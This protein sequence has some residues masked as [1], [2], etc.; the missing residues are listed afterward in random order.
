[1]VVIDTCALTTDIAI[2]QDGDR[3]L[4]GD[5]GVN[6]CTRQLTNCYK[7]LS[8]GQKARLALARTVY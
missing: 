2:L 4:I 8:G 7:P 3:T 5:K 1:Q 6:P